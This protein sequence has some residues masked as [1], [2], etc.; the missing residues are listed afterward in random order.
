MDQEFEVGD[1]VQLKSGG[2]KMKVLDFNGLEYICQ[3]LASPGN[4]EIKLFLP[5]ALESAED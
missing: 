3:P 5:T 2:P 1:I 4:E